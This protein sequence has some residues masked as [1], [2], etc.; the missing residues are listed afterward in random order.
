MDTQYLQSCLKLRGEVN[1]PPGE[2]LIDAPL[3]VSGDTH[4]KGHAQG[5]RIKTIMDCD[6]F[7]ISGKSNIFIENVHVRGSWDPGVNDVTLATAFAILGKDRRSPCQNI[8]IERCSARG[9]SGRGVVSS[10]L[11]EDVQVVDCHFQ[12]CAISVFFFK[13]N[14]C[15]QLTGCTIEDSRL[16]GVYVDD[17]TEGDTAESAIQNQ[18]TRLTNNVIHFGG[19]H[20]QN[21]GAGIIVSSSLDTIVTGNIISRFGTPE[22]FGY[23]MIINDGQYQFKTSQRTLVANNIISENSGYGMY[24]QGVRENI[25]LAG[26]LITGN[27]AGDV[28]WK[29][30]A[31]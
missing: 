14:K 10:Y 20:P 6:A 30:V 1:L 12:S 8:R 24:I 15:A 9:M 27:G 17:A 26:N 11:N 16:I 25:E 7:M 28:F 19:K 29:E 4:I 18:Y 3:Y 31:A 21:T 5:T 22:R 13:G 2:F 23:G